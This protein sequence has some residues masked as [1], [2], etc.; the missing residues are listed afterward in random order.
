MQNTAV[1]HNTSTND[2]P[3]TSEADMGGTSGRGNGWRHVTFS[4]VFSPQTQIK[5]ESQIR[6]FVLKQDTRLCDR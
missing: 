6:C 3:H 4:L 2:K 1:A 5:A